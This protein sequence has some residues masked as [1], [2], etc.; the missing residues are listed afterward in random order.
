MRIKGLCQ[1]MVEMDAFPVNTIQYNTIQYNTIW[2]MYASPVN[3]TAFQPTH[4]PKILSP[5]KK[6]I[7]KLI[8]NID[9]ILTNKLIQLNAIEILIQISIKGPF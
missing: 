4:L 2:G 9:E 3:T 6:M 5:L 7:R 1:N 8:Q